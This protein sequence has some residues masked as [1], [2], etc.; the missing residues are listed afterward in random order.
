[1]ISF[2]AAAICKLWFNRNGA[3]KYFLYQ[4]IHIPDFRC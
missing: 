4:S 2:Y 1:L 3:S